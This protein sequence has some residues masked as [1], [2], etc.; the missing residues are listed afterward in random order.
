MPGS[1]SRPVERPSGAGS[2]LLAQQPLH[3]IDFGVRRD[4]LEVVAHHAASER[5]VS[6]IGGDVDRRR[7]RIEPCE[8]RGE[9]QLRLAVLADHDRS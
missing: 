4:A 1:Y 6:G 8:E 2:H 9:R 7:L 5:A 3:A